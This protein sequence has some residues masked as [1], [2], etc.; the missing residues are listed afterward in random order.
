MCWRCPGPGLA[1][2]DSTAPGRGQ[3]SRFTAVLVRSPPCRTSRSWHRLTRALTSWLPRSARSRPPA[4]RSRREPSPQRQ[5]PP[6]TSGAR[7]RSANVARRCRPS[8]RRRRRVNPPPTRSPS[9]LR[10]R[11]PAR[12]LSSQRLAGAPPGGRRPGRVRCRRCLPRGSSGCWPTLGPGSARARSPS[13]PALAT[14]ES[15]L[16]CVTLRPL[17]G[18]GGRGTDAQPAGC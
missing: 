9:S 1:V 18:S 3:A 8:D 5:R 10:R 16:R 17:A 13:G 7:P 4:P 6:P 15:W 14:A 11:R 2:A 12:R